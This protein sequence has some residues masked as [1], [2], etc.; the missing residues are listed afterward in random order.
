MV[1][2]ENM[3]NAK[4]TPPLPVAPSLREALKTG[5]D[6]PATQAHKVLLHCALDAAC[7]PDRLRDIRVT[8]QIAELDYRTVAIVINWLRAANPRDL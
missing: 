3:L 5:V 4:M 8:T 7:V 2:K 6:L 1:T